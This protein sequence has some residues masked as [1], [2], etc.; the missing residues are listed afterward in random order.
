MHTREKYTDKGYLIKNLPW[1]MK[2]FYKTKVDGQG[3]DA[4]VSRF[5]EGENYH[6]I[7]EVWA[8]YDGIRSYTFLDRE[9][10][11]DKWELFVPTEC[12][13]ELFKALHELEKSFCGLV[14]SNN[15]NSEEDGLF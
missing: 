6:E 11:S 7:L 15:I 3:F 4:V 12:I 5:V 2:L 13:V 8:L 9:G 14:T 1:S 10:R